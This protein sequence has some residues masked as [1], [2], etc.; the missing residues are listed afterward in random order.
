MGVCSWSAALSAGHSYLQYMY[1][2]SSCPMSGC[3]HDQSDLLIA[4]GNGFLPGFSVAT[5]WIQHI[6]VLCRI[7]PNVKYRG[8]ASRS[9][10]IVVSLLIA[11]YPTIL[12]IYILWGQ[13]QCRNVPRPFFPTQSVW[14]H[15]H[16]PPSI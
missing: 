2:Q 13:L 15:S 10:A 7:T 4:N 16:P 12:Y 6:A 3:W 5:D 9:T 8:N 11:N 1:L 14:Y